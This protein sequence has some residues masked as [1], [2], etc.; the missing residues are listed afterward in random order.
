MV[1]NVALLAGGANA[2]EQ[3]YKVCITDDSFRKPGNNKVAL[4]LL[5]F[6]LCSI[7]PDEAPAAFK[8]CF[9]VLDREQERDFRKLVDA[10]LAALERAKLLP[11][12]VARKST[13]SAAGGD[14]FEQLVWTL[15]TLALKQASL[16]HPAQ[17]GAAHNP[18]PKP[19]TA[20]D[21]ASNRRYAALLRSRIASERAA[22]ARTTQMGRDSTAKWT[23][24]IATLKERIAQI[25]TRTAEVKQE[26]KKLGFDETV[27]PTKSDLLSPLL[28]SSTTSTS[29]KQ[30]PH[31]LAIKTSPI[32]SDESGSV[33][34]GGEA[35]LN[36]MLA[37]TG[38]SP[39]IAKDAENIV[40]VFDKSDQ[41]SLGT[42]ISMNFPSRD[43]DEPKSCA[44]V[45]DLV[46]AAVEELEKATSRMNDIAAASK[47][48]PPPPP[49]LSMS[50]SPVE[51]PFDAATKS[52][53]AALPKIEESAAIAVDEVVDEEEIVFIRP[54]KLT[55]EAKNSLSLHE[56]ILQST[57]SLAKSATSAT[58]ESTT[59]S[60]S[61]ESSMP[62]PQQQQHQEPFVHVKNSQELAPSLPVLS[63]ASTENKEVS[64]PMPPSWVANLVKK[65]EKN[66]V[67]EI[68]D[69]TDPADP[70]EFIDEAE[71]MSFEPMDVDVAPP[72]A[73]SPPVDS[74][75]DFLTTVNDL[76]KAH[77]VVAT[78]RSGAP[79]S[80]LSKGKKS[81]LRKGPDGR[82]RNKDG[83]VPFHQV[84]VDKNPKRKRGG[85]AVRF[86]E[87]PPSY[88]ANKTSKSSNS[89]PVIEPHPKK[90][91]DEKNDGDDAKTLPISDILEAKKSDNGYS[92]EH[93]PSA[94]SSPCGSPTKSDDEVVI[95]RQEEYFSP[96]GAVL[97]AVASADATTAAADAKATADAKAAAARL[98]PLS[99]KPAPRNMA[100]RRA[101]VIRN[102]I[103]ERTDSNMGHSAK[104]KL[105]KAVG[106]KSEKT[107]PT[108]AVG[109]ATKKS[110]KSSTS[111]KS[112]LA[113]T[114]EKPK[115]DEKRK[116]E[117]KKTSEA[118]TAPKTPEP[119]VKE[120]E[121]KQERR[122]NS[123][124][125]PEFM[126]DEPESAPSLM[127]KTKL[128]EVTPLTEIAFED[129]KEKSHGTPQSQI[130]KV[131]SNEFVP[132][133]NRQRRHST[134]G[135]KS[136][137]KKSKSK[138]KGSKYSKSASTY[139]D[140][141]GSKNGMGE[142][143]E[144]EFEGEPRRSI[145]T[146]EYIPRRTSLTYRQ[147]PNTG[148]SGG[149]GG[150]TSRLISFQSLYGR[151]KSKSKS[152]RATS[153]VHQLERESH[154]SEGNNDSPPAQYTRR[155]ASIS[156]DDSPMFS[157][158]TGADRR[159]N[160]G[161][162]ETYQ[163]PPAGEDGSVVRQT[164]STFSSGRR[165]SVFSR[166]NASGRPRNDDGT[167]K[168]R[169]KA[170]RDRIA[171]LGRRSDFS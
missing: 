24:E 12:G 145:S 98:K 133:T 104:Q 78:A 79:R 134:Q 147:G 66:V 55:E 34:G 2:F 4:P 13:V 22:F 32:E 139:P 83:E 100:N 111:A 118:P 146:P 122:N 56:A 54:S 68:E 151:R 95:S 92:D 152:E 31:P 10:R 141:P 159:S 49:P 144:Q 23:N 57:R 74:K 63:H 52:A 9:P 103:S 167:P 164:S 48:P 148:G 41:T 72:A 117:E 132:K 11:A 58:Q 94:G 121:K 123:P 131:F 7:S 3:R 110:E 29:A 60:R 166:K 169:V 21:T 130:V 102:V 73:P 81:T 64:A 75:M 128:S 62:A 124:E 160:I 80:V 67:D 16:R 129:R 59:I 157:W 50:V 90:G 82:L 47:A 165:S 19:P 69:G 38:E 142:E 127:I 27:L 105:K 15:S 46:Q 156:G 101:T 84:A 8:P 168:N 114:E 91:V 153:N 25:S 120:E 140:R 158:L 143:S 136:E 126:N 113:N 20:S 51:N 37:F 89:S 115:V 40:T 65:F 109:I 42:D 135:V 61:L 14:K 87:L 85:K 138:K 154:R 155:R 161:R 53:A 107:I 97:S 5:H 93:S 99:R 116:I 17:G 26:L 43:V 96:T 36:R 44:N 86:A 71:P 76:Q 33:D 88:T 119:V 39:G 106:K 30:Q 162:G 163:T 170:L 112:T 149:G 77:A 28:V 137:S 171:A 6:L 108:V 150:V 1:E 35:D 70:A 18:D 125:S 45:A